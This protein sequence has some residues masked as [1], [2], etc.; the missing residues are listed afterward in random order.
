MITAVIQ[1]I[2]W[3]HNIHVKQEPAAF[4]TTLTKASE[5]A[6][7]VN[8]VSGRGVSCDHHTMMTITM[9]HQLISIPDA[10]TVAGN[11]WEMASTHFG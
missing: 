7:A 2:K 10:I 1:M 6:L 8:T 4:H 9:L 11:T 3:R 5:V